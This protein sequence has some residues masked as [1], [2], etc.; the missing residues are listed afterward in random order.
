MT[1]VE[2]L[3]ERVMAGDEEGVAGICR[4]L[5]LTGLREIR[6]DIEALVEEARRYESA[7]PY[8]IRKQRENAAAIVDCLSASTV[9]QAAKSVTYPRMRPELDRLVDLL[10]ELKPKWL[11]K[12]GARLLGQP[13][14]YG[15]PLCH[16]L[17]A[18]GVCAR[19]DD[20]RYVDQMISWCPPSDILDDPGLQHEVWAFFDTDNR[21]KSLSGRWTP[22]IV[23]LAEDGV[24][25]RDRLIDAAI[26][27]L[28]M[29]VPWN[30]LMWYAS[31]LDALDPDGAMTARH[32]D[33]YLAL[34]RS[35]VPQVVAVGQRALRPHIE[36]G[37]V[38][39]DGFL[40]VA[41]L[42]LL[43][44]DKGVAL[45]Q[46]RLLASLAMD[47]A[48]AS[49]AVDAVSQ[50]FGHPHRD[51]QER[52]LTI[53]QAALD[54]TDEQTRDSV[55]QRYELLAPALR[56][57]TSAVPADD[58]P[59]SIVRRPSPR[60]DE[61]L[62]DDRFV[63]ALAAI[64]E[65]QPS[66]SIDAVIEAAFRVCGY[67]PA[68]RAELVRPLLVRTEK[69]HSWSK[70]DAF[71]KQCVRHLSDAP[72][73][74]PRERAS[75]VEELLAEALDT[76]SRGRSRPY[77]ARPTLTTG[78]IDPLELDRRLAHEADGAGPAE[79]L[80]ARLRADRDRSLIHL[81]QVSVGKTPDWRFGK[82][83]VPSLTTA[84]RGPDL[85]CSPPSPFERTWVM[86]VGT[87]DPESGET[88]WQPLTSDEPETRG[89]IIHGDGRSLD[90]LHYIWVD[91]DLGGQTTEWCLSLLPSYV[92]L[93]GMMALSSFSDIMDHEPSQMRSN[94]LTPL[95]HR[96]LWEQPVFGDVDAT[97]IA[98]GL[99]AKPVSCT[100]SA[101]EATLAMAEQDAG[102]V[103]QIAAAATQLVEIEFLKL[104]RLANS[105]E[106]LLRRSP[107]AARSLALPL[108][109]H[110]S[111]HRDAHRVMS[112]LADAF[113]ICGPVPLPD[114]VHR[115]AASPG[116]TKAVTAAKRLVQI[117]Q[118]PISRP[119]GV[120]ADPPGRC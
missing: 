51:V 75:L 116:K 28:T 57:V 99:A 25:D 32:V 106:E 53:V 52:A 89:P 120:G 69:P 1:A 30:R 43:G 47:P 93:G 86:Q 36:S 48:W 11:P 44:K 22:P 21:G 23:Q 83:I 90:V 112:V 66:C 3:A 78:A 15:W 103:T 80:A 107:L 56:P 65:H 82:T 115:I 40:D 20:P 98:C 18:R 45:V 118:S 73:G 84:W 4:A 29:Q 39:P 31:L 76:V 94:R 92:D 104:G 54:A 55:L 77:L 62:D 49:P 14:G 41:A 9:V 85:H 119:A 50:A 87:I 95:L 12:L 72:G 110:L 46:L 59:T 100:T 96:Y 79:V 105:L 109:E 5:G 71:A 34:M 70:Y 117:S 102:R 35:P 63:E 10:I 64:I 68:H 16:R 13:R 58:S 91:F 33:G 8:E 17:V 101:L 60:D 26:G 24:L 114:S 81:S 2:D 97:V 111:G 6:P 88:V 19:P 113:T 108:I 27:A 37:D 42:P 61:P 7:V 67:P 38:R 74:P